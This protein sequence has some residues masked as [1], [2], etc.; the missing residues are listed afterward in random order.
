MQDMQHTYGCRIQ[1]QSKRKKS[2]KV[3]TA[4]TRRGTVVCKKVHKML[5]CKMALGEVG[6][7]LP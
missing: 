6:M 3:R 7:S 2:I 5:W 1:K 4:L